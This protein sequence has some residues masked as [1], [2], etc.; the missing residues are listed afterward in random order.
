MD[1]PGRRLR[2]GGGILIRWHVKRGKAF[3]SLGL[4][5]HLAGLD[6]PEV[7]HIEAGTRRTH[8]LRG[9]KQRGCGQP[10][11]EHSKRQHEAANHSQQRFHPALLASSTKM[12]IGV[13]GSAE[14]AAI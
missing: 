6:G 10:E 2:L 5:V 1:S 11:G 9:K 12:R 13:F 4:R 3:E 8:R 14:P 7:G